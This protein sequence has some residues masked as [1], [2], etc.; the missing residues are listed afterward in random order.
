M[1]GDAAE[2]VTTTLAVGTIGR[3]AALALWDAGASE[4]PL[5][6]LPRIDGAP[7]APPVARLAVP[8]RWG[9]QRCLVAFR[10]SL[11]KAAAVS[12]M[13]RI[14]HIAIAERGTNALVA[15]APRTGGRPRRLDVG[16]LLD[17]LDA[18]GRIRV[19]RFILEVCRSSF[20]LGDDPEFASVCGDL[21][22]AIAAR[23]GE[24][25]PRLA[26]AAGFVLCVGAA[27]AG[28]GTPT[29]AVIV[30]RHA[31]RQARFAPAFVGGR[32]AGGQRP[33][34]L[35][36]E[37]AEASEGISV[38]VFSAKAMACRRVGPGA[39]P[40][41]PPLRRA[42]GRNAD[43]DGRARDYVLRCLAKQAA[44]DPAAAAALDE[45]R[46]AHA[47]ARAGA[48]SQRAPVHA[49]IDKWIPTPGGGLFVSGV[50]GDP[51]GLVAGL[52]VVDV[53]GDTRRWSGALHRVAA[54]DNAR[55][56]SEDRRDL[57][58]GFLPDSGGAL[59]ARLTL[60]LRSGASIELEPPAPPLG[61]RASRDAV[62]AAL[63][64]ICVTGSIIADC[65]SPAARHL[66]AQHLATR[67]APE[68]I[69]FGRRPAGP[70]VSILVPLYRTLDFLRFQLAA[71]AVDRDLRESELIYVLDSPEQQRELEHFLRGLHM[72]YDLPL[73]LAVMPDNYGYAAANN[74]GA[75][76]ARGR[77]L[78]LLNSDVVPDRSGWLAALSRALADGET[79]GAV[80]AKLL[81]DDDSLQHAGLYFE[82]DPDGAW[83]NRHYFKGYP[84]DFA[85]ACEAREV[86]AVTGACL[87]LARA[88]YERVGGLSEDYLIG[89][90]E[91]SDLCL[92]LRA[93]GKTV[94]Y[95]PDAE[96]YHFERR[97]IE[98]NTGYTRGAADAHNRWLHDQRWHAAIGA[99][100]EGAA[101][102]P[103][104]RRSRIKQRI[105]RQRIA[106]EQVVASWAKRLSGRSSASAL[107]ALVGAMSAA[108]A[109][110]EGP[111]P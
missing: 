63:P 82:K 89:D 29:S 60:A 46:L 25:R 99:L 62:L 8:T 19:A 109:E 45:F 33:F 22:A 6:T 71:F 66:Q 110:S 41:D 55:R 18:E 98:R 107:P 40:D 42:F 50:I 57:F 4:T 105:Q 54:P 90:Y 95:E 70:R 67:Q 48:A 103:P 26:V 28:F 38:I 1:Y 3:D 93:E 86:P 53:N 49:S 9:G 39:G 13:A 58:A 44:K 80:G 32:L 76:L 10:L 78:L 91:D 14:Q 16:G 87:L 69:Q 79:V 94:R 43:P 37:R 102:P 74:A 51:H 27:P 2:A 85:P 35:M 73:T 75:G 106:R 84:R 36:L 88:Q 64:P 5:Q 56:A 108:L 92:K 83:Y 111:Q 20:R 24:L 61:A 72:L 97:S 47:P 96:L 30:G 23:P 68:V 59:P 31:V 12:P 52:M 7:A 65:I 104:A 21:V 34:A 77:E 11:E 81:F 17:G 100:M 101:A 15:A